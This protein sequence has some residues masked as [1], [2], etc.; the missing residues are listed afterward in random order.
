MTDDT[1]FEPRLGPVGRGAR[2]QASQLKV[3]SRMA[4]WGKT[5]TNGRK[6]MAPG[7]V[8]NLGRGK[9]AAALARHW[10]EAGRRRAFVVVKIAPARG[11]NTAAFASHLKYIQRDGTDISGARAPLFDREDD[12]VDARRFIDRSRSDEHQFRVMVSPED[13]GSLEDL[14]EFTRRLMEQVDRDLRTQTDWVAACHYNTPKPHVHI[15][16]RGGN[17]KEGVLIIARKYLTSGLRHRA[18][19]RLT[20]ELGHRSWRE[21]SASLS[22]ES[23]RE[24][25]SSIDRALRR[26][27]AGGRVRLETGR[28]VDSVED[29]TRKSARLQQ[30]QTIGIARHIHGSDWRLSEDWTETLK[31]I[32][33]RREILDRF[34]AETGE[35][36][37]PGRALLDL[38][39]SGGEWVTGRLTSRIENPGRS[40][41]ELVLIDGLDG[42]AWV[43]TASP[44]EAGQLPKAGSIMSVQLPGSQPQL[45]PP[46]WTGAES[47]EQSAIPRSLRIFVDSWLPLD[48]LLARRAL[49]WLDDLSESSLSQLCAGFGAEVRAAKRA[50]SALLMEKP[51]GL[52]ESESLRQAELTAV[53]ASTANR[54]GKRFTELQSREVFHGEYLETIDTADGPLAVIAG[55]A[56]FTLVP[57][58]DD[59]W[60]LRGQTVSVEPGLSAYPSVLE[61]RR[62]IER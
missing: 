15:A 58:T 28:D 60:K 48:Q 9:G 25:Y 35:P 11:T 59:L 45:D 24:G 46:A 47:D 33:R 20:L 32:G 1:G 55:N 53:V 13:S 4:R 7:S 30:L 49:N 54:L 40:G 10:A 52:G 18:E 16:V 12:N 57:V 61:R 2:R 17:T 31:T 56:R 14:N 37:F 29:W 3:L 36:R 27:A 34:A 44:Q 41:G 51:L 22:R 21:Q 5:W 19:E 23:G 50:R 26:D 42:R 39:A 8:Y 6:R 62:G 38:S 43:W